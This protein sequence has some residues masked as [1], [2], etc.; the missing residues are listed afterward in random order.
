M[1]RPNF[2]EAE[3]I[4]RAVRWCGITGGHFTSS[5]CRPAKAPTNPLG[6]GAQGVPV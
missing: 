1:T 4:E 2:I 5:T 6:A 3:A